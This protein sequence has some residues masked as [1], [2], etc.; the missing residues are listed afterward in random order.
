MRLSARNIFKG[1]VVKL[2]PGALNTEVVIK[3]NE[4]VQ[5]VSHI[6]RE[7]ATNLGLEVGGT[8]YAVI[9]ASNVIIGVD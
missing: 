7:S 9:K 6:S 3:V 8:A 1:T 2:V 4:D 5:I